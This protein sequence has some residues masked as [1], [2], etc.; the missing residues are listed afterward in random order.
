MDDEEKRILAKQ[1]FFMIHE[2]E[3]K[4]MIKQDKKDRKLKHNQR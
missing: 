4:K 2:R 3:I 1:Y